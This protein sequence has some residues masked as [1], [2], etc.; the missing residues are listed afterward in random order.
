MPRGGPRSGAGAPIANTNAFKHGRSSPEARALARALFTIPAFRRYQLALARE[1]SK[2]RAL[3]EAKCRE[4][5]ANNQTPRRRGEPVARPYLSSS[6]Q[7][8]DQDPRR[9]LMPFRPA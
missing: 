5:L 6:G 7:S 4:I 3:F 8:E 1:Q 9:D 2:N